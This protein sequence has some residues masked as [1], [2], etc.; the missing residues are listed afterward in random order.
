MK[1]WVPEAGAAFT[2]V[3]L[4]GA[5]CAETSKRPEKEDR[6][7]KKIRLQQEKLKIA[8][9]RLAVKKGKSSQDKADYIIKKIRFWS[10]FKS[11]NPEWVKY[12]RRSCKGKWGQHGCADRRGYGMHGKCGK[13]YGKKGICGGK[14]FRK[15]SHKAEWWKSLK[16]ESA[17]LKALRHQ[18][19]SLK[20]AHIRIA[21]KQGFITQGRGAFRVKKIEAMHRF[22]DSNPE[23][24][25]YKHHFRKG[26]KESC[27]HRGHGGHGC[28]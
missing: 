26:R 20:I 1:K 18:H 7:M 23:W 27:G 21:M 22:K 3:F 13:G 6:D 10:A 19:K 15:E 17:D 28:W 5:A 2:L 14:G 24:V 16:N 12:K 8:K 11:N 4:I 9:I 25:K